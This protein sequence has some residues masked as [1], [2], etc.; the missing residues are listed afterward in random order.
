MRIQTDLHSLY[1]KQIRSIQSIVE[2]QIFVN[3]ENKMHFKY[4]LM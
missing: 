2:K 3:V 4:N 1:S